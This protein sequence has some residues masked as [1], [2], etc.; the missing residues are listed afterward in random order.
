MDTISYQGKEYILECE[1]FLS[2]RVFPGWWGDVGEGEAYI[3]EYDAYATSTGGDGA[4][5]VV[6]WQFDAVKGDEPEDESDYPWEDDENIVSVNE[7]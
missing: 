2:N 5:Y 4:R 1:A 3:A 7:C 6:S